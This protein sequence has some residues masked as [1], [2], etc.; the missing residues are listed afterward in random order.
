MSIAKKI[1]AASL[2]AL[3]ISTE[4]VAEANKKP[5]LERAK[6]QQAAFLEETTKHG[7]KQGEKEKEGKG[8]LFEMGEGGRD[9]GDHL[10][11]VWNK[12]CWDNWYDFLKLF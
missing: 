2:V 4:V 1:A 5:I 7:E 8:F 11:G 12:V 3:N 9:V 6:L 10:D